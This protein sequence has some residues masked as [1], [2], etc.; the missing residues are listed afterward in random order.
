[1]ITIHTEY[2]DSV[3]LPFFRHTFHFTPKAEEP[4]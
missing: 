3:D 1:M 4:L 2:S